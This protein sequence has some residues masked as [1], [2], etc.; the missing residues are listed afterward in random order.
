MVLMKA[1]IKIENAV[2]TRTKN[3]LTEAEIASFLEAARRGRHGVR[4]FPMMHLAT[5]MGCE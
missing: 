5:G 3:F 1:P 4:N 2:D